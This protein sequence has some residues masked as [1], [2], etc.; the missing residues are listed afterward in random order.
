MV[1]ISIQGDAAV[2]DVQGLHKLWAF[3]SRLKVPRAHITN[4]RADPDVATA[5]WK[6]FR[7]PGTHLPGILT[8][9]TFSKV[10]SASSGT[11]GTNRIRSWW[12]SKTI[13]TASSSL[14]WRI[15]MRRSRDSALPS[16][17]PDSW[18][19]RHRGGC[20]CN[21]RDGLPDASVRDLPICERR[22]VIV[23]KP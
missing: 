14:R 19:T 6:G 3:K 7:M 12:S 4:V 17:E 2:F 15:P 13:P 5:L 22:N 1:R 8:A 23:L 16:R 20:H 10:A 21:A 9:G 11:S 18:P